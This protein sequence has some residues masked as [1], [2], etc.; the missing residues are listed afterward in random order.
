MCNCCEINWIRFT[1]VTS[2]LT[3]DYLVNQS[4]HTRDP[5]LEAQL[6]C[7]FNN[8]LD[9]TVIT[10]CKRWFYLKSTIVVL[11]NWTNFLRIWVNQTTVHWKHDAAKR[12]LEGSCWKKFNQKSFQPILT[13]SKSLFFILVSWDDWTKKL[14]CSE[15]RR[16]RWLFFVQSQKPRFSELETRL[17]IASL[18]FFKARLR[19]VKRNCKTHLRLHD[20][21]FICSSSHLENLWAWDQSC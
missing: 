5:F 3:L 2:L 7:R 18:I 9:W 8:W 15:I 11:L 19:R 12:H 17:V 21:K 4:N 1:F 10:F 14:N 6:L 16:Q 13:K 20:C